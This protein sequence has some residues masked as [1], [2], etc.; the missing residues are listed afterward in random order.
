MGWF[1]G[2]GNGLAEA[3]AWA[4]L[5]RARG[6]KTSGPK[7]E[8]CV[9]WVWN[10][11]GLGSFLFLSPFY[12]YFFYFK[13]YSILIE[14]KYKFEFNP[15]TQTNKTMLQHDAATKFKLMIKF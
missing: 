9:G 6:K 12:F 8:G 1:R 7:E 5:G 14:F 15:S 11:A 2:K 10:Q 13:H 4:G 3:L